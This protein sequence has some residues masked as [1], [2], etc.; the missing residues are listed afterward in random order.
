M[1]LI[2]GLTIYALY[3]MIMRHINSGT[4]TML[5]NNSANDSL[6][7]G[8]PDRWLEVWDPPVVAGD[9]GG[10]D[11]LAYK[12]RVE[13]DWQ[14]VLGT[15]KHVKDENFEEY[16][17][18]SGVPAFMI[19]IILSTVPLV[20]IQKIP[21]DSDY[22]YDMDEDNVKELDNVYGDLPEDED[23][24]FQMMIKTE[25][26]IRD[27]D[28]RFKLGQAFHHVEADGSDSQNTF[29]FV[30]PRVLLLDKYRGE[31]HHRIIYQF[32]IDGYDV[33]M[34]DF[35]NNITAK[36]FFN[37]T[38]PGSSEENV[39]TATENGMSRME[40][41]SG[42][43]LNGG[44]MVTDGESFNFENQAL[45]SDR[46]EIVLEVGN[47]TDE[48]EFR[49]DGWGNGKENGT[50]TEN[51]KEALENEGAPGS[52]ETHKEREIVLQENRDSIN[53]TAGEQEE[54]KNN[55]GMTNSDGIDKFPLVP[56]SNFEVFENATILEEERANNTDL[57]TGQN[58]NN[59]TID[60]IDN[61]EK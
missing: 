61:E 12:V 52:G 54:N 36:R 47:A 5:L 53:S 59:R 1:L 15:Y 43:A 17:T 33:T 13:A 28:M 35:S 42:L 29:L 26:W 49:Q 14:V 8:I 22:Y 7:P 23:T 9:G 46:K 37:R 24:A 11:R 51:G 39:D 56:E 30:E 31:D 2:S 25:T 20:T 44:V 32:G 4:N 38:Q 10:A 6:V 34:V 19:S 58:S 40:E 41:E 45:S 48:G 50:L 3:T 55:N 57:F 21:D 18:V 60:N 27:I 16:L